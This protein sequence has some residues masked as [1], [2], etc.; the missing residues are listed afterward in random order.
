M[1]CSITHTI[2]GDGAIRALGN[3]R[4]VDNIMD[5]NPDD[6]FVHNS[7]ALYDRIGRFFRGGV[8]FKM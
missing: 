8:R 6:F 3:A 2:V 7:N 4:T 5:K 1:R